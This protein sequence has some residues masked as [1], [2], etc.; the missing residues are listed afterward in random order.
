MA[1]RKTKAKIQTPKPSAIIVLVVVIAILIAV[2]L[3]QEK[4]EVKEKKPTP[5]PGWELIEK[6]AEKTVY[7]KE[8]EKITVITETLNPIVLIA[9]LK[10]EFTKDEWDIDNNYF[11]RENKI[12]WAT[13]S[14]K[15]ICFDSNPVPAE[16]LSY[17]REKYMPSSK[18]IDLAFPETKKIVGCGNNE[19]EEKLGENCEPP[20]YMEIINDEATYVCKTKYAN[21]YNIKCAK[22]TCRCV[23]PDTEEDF[24]SKKEPIIPAP[25]CGNNVIDPGEQCERNAQCP[26]GFVCRACVL[27]LIHI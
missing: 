10:E 5:I 19:I 27:S 26:A 1:K 23:F 24:L 2:L 15:L 13:S 9:K 21:F 12:C 4:I 16:I 20:E 17:Y 3:S 7:S 18:I 14:N 22:E 8:E 11:A 6:T 25:F